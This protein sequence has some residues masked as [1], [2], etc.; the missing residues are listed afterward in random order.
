MWD[1]VNYGESSL[2]RLDSV[3][4]VASGLDCCVAWGILVPRSG[5]EPESPA[6]PKQILNH[7]TS[8]SSTFILD[9]CSRVAE[10]LRAETV[11]FRKR[12]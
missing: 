2:G 5:F 7:W 6:L 11:Y 4:V 9:L 12:G 10:N 1:L 3:A 8:K